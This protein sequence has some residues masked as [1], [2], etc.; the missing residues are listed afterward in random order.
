MIGHFR[1]SM[2]INLSWLYAAQKMKQ[3]TSRAC[4]LEAAP[5]WNPLGGQGSGI[6]HQNDNPGHLWKLYRSDYGCLKYW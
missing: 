2:I 5:L 3:R 1:M 4:S 6:A